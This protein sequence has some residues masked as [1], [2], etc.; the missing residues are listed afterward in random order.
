MDYRHITVTTSSGVLT[1]T[2][3]R[4]EVLNSL[5]RLM[6]EEIQHA[7]STFRDEASLRALLLTGAGRGFCAGQ[8][9]ASLIGAD[10]AVATDLAPIVRECYSPIIRSLRTI[11]KP[12]VAAVNGIAAG[13]GANLALACDIVIAADKA[14]FVQSFSK[15]GLVPDSGG[16]FMLPRLVGLARASAMMMLGDRIDA[17]TAQSIGLI[18]QVVPVESVMTEAQKLATHLATQPTTGLGLIKRALNAS[19]TNTL[20]EQLALEAQLQ[21]Q[22]GA[23]ADYREGVAAFLAK[24]P[25]AFVGR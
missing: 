15:V 2:L 16:T 6:A 8:D 11:E 17:T 12:I 24:R 14:S 9:L 3:N 20:D 10:G 7:L 22:A 18:H 25:A 21:G 1:L 4:P 23:T 5:N 13:A 19:L